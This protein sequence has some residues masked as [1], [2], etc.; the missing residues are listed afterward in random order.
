M[1]SFGNFRLL[2]EVVDLLV[3]FARFAP[4]Q[5]IVVGLEL[6][7]GDLE[8]GVGGFELGFGRLQVFGKFVGLE[9]ELLIF[10]FLLRQC[11]LGGF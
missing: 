8:F 9:A 7:R 1:L 5:F 11:V 3:K 4:L 6:L 2:R 10:G